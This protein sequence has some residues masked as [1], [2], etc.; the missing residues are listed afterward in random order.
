MSPPPVQ[1]GIGVVDCRARP[2]QR[3]L[4]LRTGTAPPF[5]SSRAHARDLAASVPVC[6]ESH[7]ASGD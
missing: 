5:M 7:G 3:P 6:A 4:A 1:E 2:R